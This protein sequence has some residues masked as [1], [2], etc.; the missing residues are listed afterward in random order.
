M[1]NT[2]VREQFLRESPAEQLAVI[3]ANLAQLA[4]LITARR[5]E[6]ALLLNLRE[7]QV[8]CE[9]AASVQSGEPK[10][11]LLNLQTVLGTWQQ[12]W[13][14]L[15]GQYEFRLAVVREAELWSRRLLAHQGVG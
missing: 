2:P 4:S 11:L 8:L 6:A 7:A 10:T 15:G 9:G 13:P 5:P 3:A 1:A 14:R 12:V